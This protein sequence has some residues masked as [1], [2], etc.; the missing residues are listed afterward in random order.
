MSLSNPRRARAHRLIRSA[1]A[2]GVATATAI[3][4]VACAPS[5]TQTTPPATK[6]SDGVVQIYLTRHGKTM[7]NLTERVQGWIDSPLI[8]AGEQTATDLGEGLAA[9][10]VSFA[11]AYSGDMLR[12][13]ATATG[14]LAG[15][16]SDLTPVRMPGLREMAFGSWEG[17]LGTVLWQNVA[18]R[19]GFADEA[20]LKASPDYD[21]LKSLDTIATMNA[22][23]ELTAETCDQVAERMFGALTEIAEKQSADGGGNVLVVSSGISIMCGLSTLTD[24]LP[25]FIGGIKNGSVSQLEYRKGTW[26]VK[27]VNDLSYVET[28]AAIG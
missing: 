13:Y 16:K 27:S 22:K 14:A 19:S 17:E 6:K 8:S 11:S 15:M 9:K 20:A 2:A 23:P 12:H 26:T 5:A 1:L 18:E 10:D 25:A 28:G 7:L 4:L 21:F 3:S 24:D